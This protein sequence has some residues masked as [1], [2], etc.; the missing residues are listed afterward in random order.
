MQVK[1]KMGKNKAVK[2]PKMQQAARQHK[3]VPNGVH[4][5]HLHAETV[6]YRADGVGNAAAQQHHELFGRQRGCNG[7]ISKDNAPARNQITRHGNGFVFLHINNIERDTEHRGQHDDRKDDFSN[8]IAHDH[9]REGSV[10]SRNQQKD[11]TMVDDLEALLG[12]CQFPAV[13]HRRIGVEHDH[14]RAKDRHGGC[15]YE[16]SRRNQNIHAQDKA[17][18][19]E[20]RAQ[21][22][23]N[24]VEYLLGEGVGGKLQGLNAALAAHFTFGAHG[25]VVIY[26]N[27]HILNSSLLSDG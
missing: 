2:A 21:G 3:E 22:M 15:C 27:I 11:R 16:I 23:G 18:H 24:A 14:R 4:I 7:A 26:R 10:G 8:G 6:E 19:A 20:Y 12:L 13:I 9:Q 17:K 1:S 5:S 25:S